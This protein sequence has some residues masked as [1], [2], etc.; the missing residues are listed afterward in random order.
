[1]I[2]FVDIIVVKSIMV[3]FQIKLMAFQIVTGCGKNVFTKWKILLQSMY[4]VFF[5][6]FNP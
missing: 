6:R 5:I 4:K 2:G 1:M 3:L